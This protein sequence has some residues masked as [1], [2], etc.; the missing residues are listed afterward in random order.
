MEI[1]IAEMTPADYDETVALWE[2]CEGVCLGDADG[3]EPITDYLRRNPAMSFIA[4]DSGALVGAVLCGTDGR[5]GYLRHLAVA[6]PH[7]KSGLGRKLVD[8]GLTALGEAGVRRCQVVV[9]TENEAGREFWRR[10]GW[11][12][13]DQVRLMSKLTDA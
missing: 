6:E 10:I 5:G 4:R 8:R 12:E 1:E 3:R 13:P 7:R 9:L 11:I 2:A